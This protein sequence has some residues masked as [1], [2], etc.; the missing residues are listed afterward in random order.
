MTF[1]FVDITSIHTILE[2]KT[3]RLIDGLAPVDLVLL[4]LLL[5]PVNSI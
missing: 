3:D 5:E 2:D 4:T 1:P